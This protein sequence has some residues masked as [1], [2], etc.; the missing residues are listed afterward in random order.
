MENRSRAEQTVRL[1]PLDAVH[2]RVRLLFAL[3]TVLS[4]VIL[5][6]MGARLADQATVHY[7]DVG[8]MSFFAVATVAL[9]LAE[10]SCLRSIRTNVQ[11]QLASLVLRDE[12]T[13][14]YNRRYI[15]ERID[16]EISFGR[17]HGRVFS[18]LYI[19]LDGF[20]QVND[21]Y[22]HESGDRVLRLV[23]QWIE[24]S[25]RREDVVARMG[26]DEFVVLLPD[27]SPS[28]AAN[29]V[30]RLDTRF[31]AQSFQ[32]PNGEE[33]VSLAFSAGIAAFPTDG[34]TSAAVISVA[35]RNMYAHKNAK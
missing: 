23:G 10:I 3:L 2:S 17:R 29:L 7:L 24:N 16:R 26:G 21:R 18:V 9:T 15:C 32:L 22:G 14:L 19:D 12:I 1:Q 6:T 8:W 30:I 4:L 5:I 25:V 28:D 27:T 11:P 34:E 31:K 20:K 35:D 33:T 13:G